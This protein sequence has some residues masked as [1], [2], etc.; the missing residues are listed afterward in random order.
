MKDWKLPASLLLVI[1][2]GLGLGWYFGSSASHVET[3]ATA[4][5]TLPSRPA[6]RE[7]APGDARTK[8]RGDQ[9]LRISDDEADALGALANQR[10]ITF[11]SAEAMRAF[12]DKIAGKGIAVLGSIDALH[13]LRIGFL[14]PSELAALLDGTEELGFIFPAYIPGQGGVQAGAVGFGSQYLQWLGARGDRSTWGNGVVVAILD[15]GVVPN[16]SFPGQIQSQALV[17]FPADASAINGHG[18]A[19]AAII[20]SELGLAPGSKILDFR[21]ADDSGTSDTYLIAQAI[22]AATDAGANVINISLGSTGSSSILRKAVEYAI[23]AGVVVVASTGNNGIN[24]VA[25]P[26]GYEG[27]VAVGAVDARGEILDFSNRGDVTLVA[28]GLALTTLGTQGQQVSFSG[29][30]ASAPAVSGAIAATMTLQKSTA[31]QA[32]STVINQ[33]NEAGAPG[34]DSYY[35]SGILNVGRVLT[36]DQPNFDDAAVASNHFTY[37]AQGNPVVE[38]VVENRGTTSI[39]NAPL[40]VTTPSG[41]RQANIASLI[42][43]GIQT[44]TFPL[45]NV[46]EAS[47]SSSIQLSNG[48]VDRIPANNSRVDSFVTPA[49]E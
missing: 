30:S 36:A 21:V 28:P 44:F 1:A 33:A 27:V 35:G 8:E 29:T 40:T 7:R 24:Q 19:V 26:A 48:T 4:E 17:E 11:A 49:A 2:L 5:P 18:T 9:P 45:G 25:Y 38:V 46:S 10:T 22:L 42:P 6:T 39:I 16:S 14:D 12:L 31:T 15:T 43:G 37:D 41:T 34:D 23:S 3:R 32:L 20:A 13:T 47:I